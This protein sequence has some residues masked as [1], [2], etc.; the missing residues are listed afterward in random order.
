MSKR[1][2][3]LIF[4]LLLLICLTY[5]IHGDIVMNKTKEH[6][7]HR[8]VSRNLDFSG[9]SIDAYFFGNA[10]YSNGFINEE[11]PSRSSF[12]FILFKN[13]LLMR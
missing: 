12:V 4:S 3:F 13:F 5:L 11:I 7:S 2:I 10:I 1:N 6:M 8:K 9:I